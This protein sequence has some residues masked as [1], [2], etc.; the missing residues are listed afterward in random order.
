MFGWFKYT[1]V[2][3]FLAVLLKYPGG[4]EG[5]LAAP[6]ACTDDGDSLALNWNE[7][8]LTGAYFKRGLSTGL[9]AWPF[10]GLG[11]AGVGVAGYY[12]FQGS[13]QLP[14]I[15]ARD[16]VVF[17]GCLSSVTFN[18]LINDIGEGLVVREVVGAP[19]GINVTIAAGG[20]LEIEDVGNT[21]FEFRYRIGDV[22][23]QQS[24]AFVRVE[25]QAS[26]LIVRNDEAELPAGGSV[27]FNVLNNDTGT[28]LRVVGFTTPASG[29]LTITEDGSVLYVSDEQESCGLVEFSYTV[30]DGCGQRA[31]GQVVIRTLDEQAPEII[32]P[33]RFDLACGQSADPD[34][35]GRPEVTDACD[36]APQLAYEDTPGTGNCPVAATVVRLWSARDVSG[37]EASCQ[38]TIR[39]LDEA[40]PQIICPSDI[41]IACGT[42]RLPAAT[43]KAVATDD[44]TSTADIQLT[45]TDNTAGLNQCGGTGVI[46][47]TWT[48]KDKCGKTATCTQRITLTD[49]TPPV[50]SCPANITIGCD[51]GINPA[52][53]GQA[54][55]VDQ[56]GGTEGLELT[57]IDQITGS[58][59]CEGTGQVRRTWVATDACGNTSTC[60]QIIN[61]EPVFGPTITCPPDKS[62]A[63]NASLDPANTGKPTATV[64]CSLPG[65]AIFSYTDNLNGLVGCNGTGIVVRSWK[66][67]DPC[68]LS[69]ACT[70]IISLTDKVAPAIT[71]PPDIALSCSDSRLPEKTGTA[72][73]SDNCG[74]PGDITIDYSDNVTG[75]TGCNG[76]G[77]IRRTWRARDACGNERTCEQRITV[78]DETA[79]VIT[80]PANVTVNCNGSREPAV[81]GRAIATDNCTPA[82]NIAITYTDNTSGLN[83]CGGTGVVV[84]TWKAVD[85]CGNQSTCEQRITVRDITAPVI[86]CPADVTIECGESLL[87]TATGSATATD[88]CTARAE[89]EISYSDNTAGLNGCSGT[90][91][92]LRT[93]TA[94]DACGNQS[95]CIQRITVRDLAPPV[96][97]CPANLT[98]SVNRQPAPGCYGHGDGHRQLFAGCRNRHQLYRQHRR[99]DGLQRHGGTGAHLAGRRRLRQPEHLRAAHHHPGC[100][101]APDQL[102]A[103]HY[104][105]VHG[106][107][108]SGQHRA[109]HR[110]GQLHTDGLHP[111]QLYRRSDRRAGL[112]CSGQ[113]R[114]HLAGTG[115]LRPGEHLRAD[116]NG[117]SGT[118]AGHHL[119]AQYHHQLFRQPTAGGYGHSDGYGGLHDAGRD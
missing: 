115:C 65:E 103:A 56:C 112:Q 54:T 119:S 17:A 107:Q 109:G 78:R 75:L 88:N 114:P 23:G 91:V 27:Q 11:A 118:A 105:Q 6:G 34:I 61:I 89:I 100:I 64:S 43:G 59:N 48:A 16:D 82:E 40:P 94:T 55:A 70:Q 76:T 33:P 2:F 10:I 45:Y 102:S 106:E 35:T 104:H 80:C 58:I 7:L 90:G 51:V 5:V 38:Q 81:T 29:S 12:L 60:I 52:V 92:L 22:H 101:I 95:T 42:S 93:W 63:C 68:N 14:D 46:V 110:D 71:C 77:L 19:P 113:H 28:S 25:V 24:E 116:H 53:T 74:D 79:P 18:V 67:T 57:Y 62:I 30:E 83:Q 36:P 66:V 72:T 73:A 47:R 69:A 15:E 8:D 31:E 85:A 50:I 96:I 13:G 108:P 97:T 37:N 39:F 26:E 32:C 49:V 98:I 21:S 9:P 20:L 87:P 117:R 41:V 86:T 44:C 99:S 4:R 84:R 3:F 111:D 1:A